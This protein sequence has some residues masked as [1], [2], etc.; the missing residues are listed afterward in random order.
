MHTP[1][2]NSLQTEIFAFLLNLGMTLTSVCEL[3]ALDL[4]CLDLGFH[5]WMWSSILVIFAGASRFLG[6]LGYYL[7]SNVPVLEYVHMQ[8]HS[9]TL[10]VL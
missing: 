3:A 8:V 4:H 10:V 6:M 9:I 1:T 7:T 2:L 5:S